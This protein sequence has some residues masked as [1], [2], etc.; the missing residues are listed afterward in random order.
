MTSSRDPTKAEL[1]YVV[2]HLV[3]SV[4]NGDR[5]DKKHAAY[6]LAR[7]LVERASRAAE[8]RS[9]RQALMEA[10]RL[11]WQRTGKAPARKWRPT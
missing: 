2:W 9:K 11:E 1:A 7:S 8:L 10:R 3:A 6:R 5:V 4:G